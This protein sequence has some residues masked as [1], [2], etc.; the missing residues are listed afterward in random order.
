MEHTTP[1]IKV[2]EVGKSGLRK[3]THHC[4]AHHRCRIR[5]V[6]ALS[7]GGTLKNRADY[8]RV[9]TACHPHLVVV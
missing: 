8:A 2:S 3:I 5:L 4:I 9:H 7:E 6:N 1:A